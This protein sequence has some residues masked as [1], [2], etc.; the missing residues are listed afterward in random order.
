MSERKAAIL[1]VRVE[2]EHK[3]ALDTLRKSEPD[4]PTQAE[5]IRRLIDR[6]AGALK[7]GRK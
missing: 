2:H 5:M 1:H 4:L 3:R 7:K 6:A